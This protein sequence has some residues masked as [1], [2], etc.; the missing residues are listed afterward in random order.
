[1]GQTWWGWCPSC[2]LQ[3]CHHSVFPV[4]TKDL[5]AA[6]L[7]S[8][9][10]AA[11][12]F[13]LQAADSIW[14]GQRRGQVN[15]WAPVILATGLLFCQG[16]IISGVHGPKSKHSHQNHWNTGK[17]P[18]PTK[19][20][21]SLWCP[22]IITSQW[23]RPSIWKV[24]YLDWEKGSEWQNKEGGD[25]LSGESPEYTYFQFLSANIPSQTGTVIS[26]LQE[27]SAQT[28]NPKQFPSCY[29]TEQK[30]K[31][32]LGGTW[33]CMCLCTFLLHKPLI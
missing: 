32:R 22:E 8:Q 29:T 17:E 12:H 28:V 21:C 27:C 9:C 2:V 7:Q 25:Y 31:K 16:N 13:H 23:V 4:W 5:T 20:L 30:Q 19:H 14:S 24:F 10:S 15:S 3:R 6:V 26:P 1:M 33:M 18:K 11:L